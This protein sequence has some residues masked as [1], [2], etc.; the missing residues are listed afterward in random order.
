MNFIITLILGVSAGA[1]CLI[2]WVIEL[3][4]F[5]DSIKSYQGYPV[6]KPFYILGEIPKAI[7][8]IID[9][10]I[11]MI[12]Q[13]IFSMGAGLVGGIIAIWISNI[14]SFWLVREMRRYICYSQL[15]L[16]L[17]HG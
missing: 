6:L 15:S 1:V 12:F 8:F 4:P 16:F 10:S 11:T 2:C 9:I 3:R 13:V 17:V 7:P 5:L 14:F